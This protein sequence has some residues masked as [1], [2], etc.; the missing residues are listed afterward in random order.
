MPLSLRRLEGNVK[1]IELE[2]LKFTVSGEHVAGNIYKVN[3]DPFGVVLEDYSGVYVPL[4]D[5]ERL[6]RA[7]EEIATYIHLRDLGGADAIFMRNIA[8]KAL[9]VKP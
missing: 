8:R 1:T 9:E 6:R 2:R 4:A 5:Y 7:L 3:E